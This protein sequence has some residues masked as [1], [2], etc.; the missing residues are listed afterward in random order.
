MLHTKILRNMKKGKY[1]EDFPWLYKIAGTEED[2][3]LLSTI[4][5]DHRK[6]FT[7]GI[8]PAGDEIFSI[9][10]GNYKLWF[11]RKFAYSSVEIFTEIFKYNNHTVLEE[12]KGK[13]AK[14]IIDIGACEGYYT[15]K[16]K[17]NNPDAFIIA[18]EPNPDVFE[19]LKKN[20]ESN[21]LKNVKLLNVAI[22]KEERE[23]DFE[24]I[25]Q[26]PAISSF[27]I[28][29]PWVNPKW[30]KRVKIKTYSLP[31]IF[32][33]FELKEVD[34]LKIDTE[35]SEY[36]ILKSAENVLNR[37]N[38][39]VVEYHSEDLREEII[40]FLTPDFE[41]IFENKEIGNSY[42]ELYFMKKHKS[43]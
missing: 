7:Q 42:G 23:R 17:E 43:G 12:F 40:S 30:I 18:I 5:E 26:V 1:F 39:I 38:K 8:L 21:N 32:N 15:L 14:V 6:V 29:K 36:D 2:K 16:I 24:F 9:N 25:P 41:I 35:G 27:K 28:D 20:I 22:D 4:E 33:M 19:I 34:I 3:K 31:Q 37:I 11:K 13:D 10:L